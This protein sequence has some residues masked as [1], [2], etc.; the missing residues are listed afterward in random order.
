MK[1]NILALTVILLQVIICFG[2]EIN[3]APNRSES[4]ATNSCRKQIENKAIGLSNITSD[5][6][7]YKQFEHC[8]KITVKSL[9]GVEITSY[10]LNYFL[11]N[12]ADLLEITVL[13]DKISEE[14]I[15]RII[16][17][18]IKRL[19]FS[20]VTGVKGT[21]RILIGYRCFTLN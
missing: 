15:E 10:K 18:G 3:L 17:A 21:E 7:T 2:Q 8:D 9:L 6:L 12:G 19:I 13:N 11:P 14:L 16:A 1:K 5:T 4:T 20:E